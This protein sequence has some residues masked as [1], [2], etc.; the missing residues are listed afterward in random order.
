MSDTYVNSSNLSRFWT[1]A[2]SYVDGQK[3][4]VCASFTRRWNGGSWVVTASHTFAQLK[5]QT[6]LNRRVI[7]Y[8]DDAKDTEISPTKYYRCFMPLQSESDSS[9]IFKGFAA[10]D[11]IGYEIALEMTSAG[12]YNVTYTSVIQPPSPVYTSADKAALT[13]LAYDTGWVDISSYALTSVITP[14]ASRFHIRKVG[15]VVHLRIRFTLVSSLAANTN[16][17]MWKRDAV[18]VMTLVSA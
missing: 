12:A 1:N 6:A 15:K 18:G 3:D 9:L 14:T 10:Y 2:K 7:M 4:E 13:D 8:F 11:N 17:V 16:L 5:V